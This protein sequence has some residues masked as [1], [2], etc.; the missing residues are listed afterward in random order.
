MYRKMLIYIKNDEKG[1][2]MLSSLYAFTMHMTSMYENVECVNYYIQNLRK[3]LY[4]H[5][6]TTH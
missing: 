2:L 1:L 4:K 6:N 5:M 3:R